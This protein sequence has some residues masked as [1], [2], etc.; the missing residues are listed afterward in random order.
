MTPPLLVSFVADL[1][2]SMR[3]ESAATRLGFR[4]MQIEDADEIAPNDPTAPPR[5]WAEHLQGRGA[6]LLDKLTRWLPALI[7]FAQNS[8][9][10]PWGEWIALIKSVPATRRL[11]VIAFGPHKNVTALKQAKAAGA[12]AV[13]ARSAFI[14]QLPHLIDKFAHIPDY[15]GITTACQQPLSAPALEGLR[16]FN[17]GEHF[18][19]HEYLEEAW[20]TDDSPAKELYRAILQ[21]AVAYLQ[22]ERGNYR[23]AV[24]MFLRVRQWLAPLPDHC[25][26]VDLAQLRADAQRVEAALLQ[27]GEDRIH[28]FDHSL[29]KPI[30][31]SQS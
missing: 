1:Y 21:I 13:L 11:P 10:I 6:V 18:K 7:I 3:I 4:T 15:A 16:L 9:T 12:D 14:N 28:E 23:G 5:Q 20:N 26:G 24:K 8:T 31:Y 27:L 30:R 29:L 17:T 25:R 2:F 22:I 19:A